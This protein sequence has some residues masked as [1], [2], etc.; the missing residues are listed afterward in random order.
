MEN[1]TF[2][3][4]YIRDRSA[5]NLDHQS[6]VDFQLRSINLKI[7]AG[8]LVCLQGPVGKLMKKIIE[9]L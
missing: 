7:R 1:V 9:S 8:E 6:V 2:E 3:H 5:Q 4:E